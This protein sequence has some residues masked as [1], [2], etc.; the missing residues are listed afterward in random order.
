[1]K[2]L[3]KDC[4]TYTTKEG[5]ALLKVFPTATP[6]LVFELNK[7][8]LKPFEESDSSLI[9]REGIK[10]IKGL[11]AKLRSIYGIL[12]PLIFYVFCNTKTGEIV[13]VDFRKEDGAQ[14]STWSRYLCM[15]L[16]KE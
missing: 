5:W 12:E 6:V 15:S 11:E 8:T 4:K 14:A 3:K 2:E 9:S 1:M 16:F 10:K 7:K 13:I